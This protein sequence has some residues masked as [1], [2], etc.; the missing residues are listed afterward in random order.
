MSP[1][2]NSANVGCRLLCYLYFSLFFTVT[3]AFCFFYSVGRW[4]TSLALA[5]KKTVALQARRGPPP[6][7]APIS[8]ESGASVIASLASLAPPAV[9]PVPSVGQAINETKEVPIEVAAQPTT[10]VMPLP[11]LGRAE[12]SVV[13]V[14]STT[15]GA[16]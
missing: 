11:T 14:A 2:P 10:K 3:H 16:A 9:V 4:G 8:G 6:D 5:P 15:A 12:L 13:P 1:S 7:V